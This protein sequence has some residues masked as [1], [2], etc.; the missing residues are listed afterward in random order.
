MAFLAA[1]PQQARL[2]SR[3]IK[4]VTERNGPKRASPADLRGWR[5]SGCPSAGSANQAVRRGAARQVTP[6]SRWPGLPIC[7]LACW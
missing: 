1:N 2:A 5:I 6:V 4:C 7:T 3:A